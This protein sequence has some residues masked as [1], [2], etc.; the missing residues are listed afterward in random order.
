MKKLLSI[1]FAVLIFLSGMH[2][3]I[4][5]HVCGGEVAAVKWS[6]D[7]EKATC[8]METPIQK[9]PTHK[10]IKSNCCQNI[11]S[12]Y[13]VDNNYNPSSLQIKEVSKNLSQVFDLPLSITLYSFIAE[14][15][16][17]NR[18]IPPDVVSTSAVSLADIC[19]FRI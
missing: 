14:N 13:A 16:V 12:V 15:S 18:I 10:E 1:L 11:V 3:S 19:V 4:A 8:G 17:S 7:G 9:C 6:F 2:F 5:T